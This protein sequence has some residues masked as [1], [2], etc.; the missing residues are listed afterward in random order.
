MSFHF[1]ALQIKDWMAYREEEITFSDI[2]EG[3]NL[4]TIHGKNGYGKTSLFRALE[5]LFH[6][7]LGGREA[8]LE[9]WHNEASEAEEGSMEIAMKFTYRDRRFKLIRK[10]EFY[11]HAHHD[12][13]ATEPSLQLINVEAGNEEEGQLQDKINLMIPEESR[14]FVF[15]DGADIQRYAQKQHGDGVR[16]AIERVLGIPAVRNL[17]YDLGKLTEDLEEEQKKIGIL[18][19]ES[20]ELVQEIDD[21]Q[22][23]REN[24]Q[25]QKEDKR[26]KLQNTEQAA[27]ELE[28]EM[29]ELETIRAEREKLDEKKR[30]LADREEQRENITDRIDQ[31][32]S[33][34]PLH[35]LKDPL[36]QIVQE[37]QAQHEN[38]SPSRHSEY[39]RQKEFLESLLEEESCVCDRPL[40]EDARSTIQEEIERLTELTDRTQE[41]SDSL[42]TIPELN[43]L[44]GRLESLR[45]PGVDPQDLMDQ[46]A[47][48]DTKIEE[49]ETDIHRLERELEEHPDVSVQ[50][51][52]RQQKELAQRKAELEQKIE[53]L[54]TNID[55]VSKK[56]DEKQRRLDE[57]TA[58]TEDGERVTRTL[59]EA[60]T[61]HTAVE[62][63]V[64]RLV[65]EKREA[66]EENTSDI[67]TRITNKPLEY[68]GV[69]VNEDYT[70]EVYLNDGTAVKNEKLS[71]GEKEV[72]AYSF[73]TA[74]NLSSPDPAPFVMDTP[75]GQL[76]NTHRDRLLG[77]LQE[78]DVQVILLATDRDLPDEE[79]ERI[80][81]VV[82]DEF[83]IRRNQQDAY[84]HIE[85]R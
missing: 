54:E 77:S 29:A 60:R 55:R 8:Y 51:Q 47:M 16:E 73:I 56:I 27:R 67:F 24:Y 72:L 13:T 78:L 58:N 44:A 63:F 30:R 69:N 34:A 46:R 61:L 3:E 80:Q 40:T 35:M 31:F 20:E 45:D 39:K 53:N 64:D 33:E 76:D 85:R 4:V 23:E 6:D 70:L 62:T 84:S 2:K 14:Q 21:L 22:N 38:G 9:H 19:G 41:S 11:P 36:E 26:E 25:K 17:E 82:A 66:I 12:T 75:F 50:E 28:Q 10:V 79:R 81:D 15:F 18:E 37:G 49:I 42:F 74:L 65:D 68:A 43:Q 71:K 59:Q 57:V 52:V 48:L 5:F 7:P 83:V 1:E 32:L